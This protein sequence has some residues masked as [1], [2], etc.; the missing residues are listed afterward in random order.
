[1]ED[2]KLSQEAA[3]QETARFDNS[4]REFIKR[5]F[6]AELEDPVYYDLVINT[7]HLAFQAAASIVVEASSFKERT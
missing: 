1:M 6:K 5:H 4:R 3:K 2:L 7:E